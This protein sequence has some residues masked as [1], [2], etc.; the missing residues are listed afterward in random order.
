[1]AKRLASE[2]HGEDLEVLDVAIEVL[3][4]GEG[5]GGLEGVAYIKAALED[6]GT[7]N[8]DVGLSVLSEKREGDGNPVSR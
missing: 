7:V 1:M 5:V 6:I 3:P 8:F 2:G 4:N